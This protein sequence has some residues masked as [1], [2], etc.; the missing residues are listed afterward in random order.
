MFRY[1]LWSVDIKYSYSNRIHFLYTSIIGTIMSNSKR[2]VFAVIYNLL[3]IIWLKRFVDNAEC[4]SFGTCIRRGY[5]T[6]M[7][8]VFQILTEIISYRKHLKT[9]FENITSALKT[10]CCLEEFSPVND[11]GSRL[12]FFRE[13]CAWRCEG[14]LQ[15]SFTS[16]RPWWL[17]FKSLVHWIQ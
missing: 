11:E 10:F 4:F 9:L 13:E 12:C 8:N 3:V 5:M 7:K 1:S 2:M 14:L 6:I 17:Q 16:L 15:W